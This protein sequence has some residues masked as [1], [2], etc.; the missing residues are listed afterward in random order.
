MLIAVLMFTGLRISEACA[1][2]WRHIDLAGGRLRVPGTKTAAAARWVRMMPTLRDE[3]GAH[4]ASS[5]RTEPDDRVLPPL[6][7][8]SAR[9]TT[10][11][12]GC[13]DQ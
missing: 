12:S 10:R 6:A 2:R 13:G 11:T 8:L 5:K 3:L 4:K 9:R 7:G 1:L